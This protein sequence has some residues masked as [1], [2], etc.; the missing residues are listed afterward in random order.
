MRKKGKSELL[1]GRE[2][3][4][5][6]NKSELSNCRSPYLKYVDALWLLEAVV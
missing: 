1:K 3:I 5:Y 2:K 4:T 6:G